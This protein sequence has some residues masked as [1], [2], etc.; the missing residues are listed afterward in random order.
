MPEKEYSRQ[1]KWKCKGPVVEAGAACSRNG[2]AHSWGGVS[3]GRMTSEFREV[4]RGQVL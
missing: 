4:G 2:E 3:P 1:R